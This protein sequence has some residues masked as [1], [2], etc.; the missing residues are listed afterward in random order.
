[1]QDFH[2]DFR[3][4][5][6]WGLLLALI[7]A[8]LNLYVIIYIWW[9]LPGRPIARVFG[10]FTFA[11]M[12]WQLEDTVSRMAI[13]EETVRFWDNIFCLGWL[14]VGPLG[15]YFS[16]LY[17]NYKKW[18][19]STLILVVLFVPALFFETIF[20][21]NLWQ[22]DFKFRGFWGWVDDHNKY[23][24]DIVMVGWIA[25][26]VVIM[27]GVLS[28]NAWKCRNDLQKK[29]PSLLLFLGLLFPTIIG[30]VSQ[31]FLPIILHSYAIPLTSVG[32]S[33]FSVTAA[34]ALKK[35]GFLNLSESVKTDVFLANLT[36][37]VITLSS[38]NEITYLNPYGEELLGYTLK[39]ASLEKFSGPDQKFV[40]EIKNEV[41]APVLMGQVIDNYD[42]VIYT[43][44]G[45]KI[46]VLISADPII[47]E[48]SVRGVLIVARSIADIKKAEAELRQKN[49][50]LERSN[51]E[52][53]TFAF[54]ASHD[55]KEP[56]RMVSN[57]TQLI[58]KRYKHLLDS[59]GK[60]FIDF[61]VE[62]VHRMQHLINDLLSYSSI[63][64]DD[65]KMESLNSSDILAEAKKNLNLKIIE[66][67]AKIIIGPMPVIFG[68]RY[69]LVQ[70]FQNLIENGIKYTKDKLPIIEVNA[71]KRENEWIFSVR[72]NGIGI[73]PAY[74]DKVF[75]LF[76]RLHDRSKF[77]GSGIGLTV[78]KKIIE[79]HGGKIW[80]DSVFGQGTTFFF[81]IPT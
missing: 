74:K 25:V 81:S 65:I 33:I 50:E 56:L 3:L 58:A 78:C 38:K 54:V 30:L 45:N 73:D 26:L 37:I 59:E 8:L 32:L 53:E 79:L 11:L 76:Q 64:K 72:D 49:K 63:G 24:L 6:I 46:P 14:F 75:V 34:I 17:I 55:M 18:I 10:M 52:L 27:V 12:L 13:T 42:C 68:V 39:E 16:L 51:A 28:Y 69:Q 4:Y 2:I 66:T 9:A 77:S 22:H 44:Q 57:Y 47:E 23:P 41:L 1:M 61:A 29:G 48:K 40:Y 36:D 60:E 80:L 21:M 35:Y 5:N 62:G 15:L 7:P 31:V 67:G 70:L 19:K 43:K 20:R 71:M